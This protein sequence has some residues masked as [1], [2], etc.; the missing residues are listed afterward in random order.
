[1]HKSVE[2]VV[3]PTDGIPADRHPKSKWRT[4][5]WPIEPYRYETV[6]V[7]PGPRPFRRSPPRVA[8][9]YKGSIGDHL[10]RIQ[11]G[12]NESLNSFVEQFG[13]HEFL[14]WTQERDLAAWNTIYSDYQTG[15]RSFA[16]TDLRDAWTDP[17]TIKAFTLD[18]LPLQ[19]AYTRAQEEGLNEHVLSEVLGL[20]WEHAAVNFDPVVNVDTGAIVIRPAHIFAR[21][22]L[23]LVTSIADRGLTP[24][25][26]PNC[27]ETFTPKRSDQDYC[28][29]ECRLQFADKRRN[30]AQRR[31]DY[32]KK[33]Q[34][35]QRG[36]ITQA[37]YDAWHD[38]WQGGN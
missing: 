18:L 26:C 5:T 21:A 4:V 3:L 1:M 29:A 8:Y 35:M 12:D 34:Q 37:E 16:G 7:S 32:K 11:P 2:S 17:A 38:E 13:L 6:W 10:I 15:R 24:R 9:C 23:E 30:K 28:R 25:T 22:W 33:H 20:A 27:H 19:D 36:T 14:E 31:K